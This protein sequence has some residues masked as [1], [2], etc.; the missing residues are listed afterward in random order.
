MTEK[1]HYKYGLSGDKVDVE[2]AERLRA[3]IRTLTAELAASERYRENLAQG[4]V[5]QADRI[6]ALEAALRK[7]EGMA[8]W[9]ENHTPE[10]ICAFIKEVFGSTAE[11]RDERMASIGLT[12]SIR[13][14]CQAQNERCSVT[15]DPHCPVH[16]ETRDEPA[17]GETWDE[18][19]GRKP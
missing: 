8:R 7:V 17:Y 13:C 10:R 3:Q 15:L 16:S 2:V 5:D 14:T 1:D 4:H 18:R 19:V 6:R 11:T 12:N 9:P